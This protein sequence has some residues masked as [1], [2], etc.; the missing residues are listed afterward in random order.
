MPIAIT[1][2]QVATLAPNVRPNYRAAFTMY[3]QQ[4]F[5]AFGISQNALRTAHF[6]AQ[7]L[8]ESG[9]LAIEYENLNYSAARLPVV[10]PT[11]F[12]PKGPLDPG[13]YAHNPEK[14][15]NSVYGTRMGNTQPGDGY[16]FRG[17]GLIQ[18]TGRDGYAEATL[19]VRRH[20]PAAP[21]LAANP[22]AVLDPAWCL[23]VAAAEWEDSGCN[24]LAD[25]DALRAITKA[26]NG[27]LIGLAE[28]GEWLKRTKFVWH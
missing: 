20:F 28:R 27:G 9:G 14:L 8:H 25:N 2:D 13:D 19:G 10:W 1:V 21:D 17:R 3:G 4:V 16:K 11:R 18:T 23:A 24:A 5:D 26:I 15:A 12:K 7:V 22:D 6:M